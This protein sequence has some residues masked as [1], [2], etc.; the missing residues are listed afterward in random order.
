MA[1]QA[2]KP[3]IFTAEFFHI[4]PAGTLSKSTRRAIRLCDPTDVFPAGKLPTIGDAAYELRSRLMAIAADLDFDPD[5]D[6]AERAR[7]DA[8][9]AADIDDNYVVLKENGRV[10]RHA[11]LE[12]R[13]GVFVF[14]DWVLH[15]T[16][17]EKAAAG[18]E[19]DAFIAKCEAEDRAWNN[20]GAGPIQF[21]VRPSD[22]DT[23]FRGDP[24]DF[25]KL[26]AVTLAEAK[27]EVFKLLRENPSARRLEIY[28]GDTPI[29]E[30]SFRTNMGWSK[31]KDKAE[32]TEP[33]HLKAHDA[34]HLEIEK[35]ARHE[36]ELGRSLSRLREADMPKTIKKRFLGLGS[37]I[38]EN[39]KY[40]AHAQKMGSISD[41]FFKTQDAVDVQVKRLARELD[42]PKPAAKNVAGLSQKPGQRQAQTQAQADTAT[43]TSKAQKANGSAPRERKYGERYL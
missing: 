4:D 1:I 10:V 23:F 35:L 3:D 18:R 20:T 38:I 16:P 40:A 11:E 24:H 39:P 21:S 15:Q 8:K 2:I 7:L 29:C 33:V 13:N 27:A 43:R 12:K 28:Q 31:W 22:L 26:K 25:V 30:A 6:R 34:Q 41:A 36:H 37:K 5:A 42:P 32:P 9:T 19:R 14:K 17:A